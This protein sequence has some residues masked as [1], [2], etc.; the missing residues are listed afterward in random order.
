MFRA[1]ESEIFFGCLPLI[2]WSFSLSLG[3]NA[4]SEEKRYSLDRS[5]KFLEYIQYVSLMPVIFFKQYYIYLLPLCYVQPPPERRSPWECPSCSPSA[6]SCCSLWTSCPR[7]PANSPSWVWSLKHPV[8]RALNSDWSVN[9]CLMV[10][11]EKLFFSVMH[12]TQNTISKIT[13]INYFQTSQK[14]VGFVQGAKSGMLH[15][16]IIH[17]DLMILSLS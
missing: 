16:L 4:T 9:S 13:I 12:W 7:T 3:V 5:S 2:L 17:L 10:V 1:S 15:E 6:C 14:L 8:G 11:Y